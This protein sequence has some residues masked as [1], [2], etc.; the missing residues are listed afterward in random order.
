M[1]K[2]AN[3][4]GTMLSAAT[5]G[6]VSGAVYGTIGAHAA[7]G[8]KIGRGTLVAAGAGAAIAAT[9]AAVYLVAKS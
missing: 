3:P 2:R 5:A 9:F 8:S 7:K 1:A 6:A 4:V